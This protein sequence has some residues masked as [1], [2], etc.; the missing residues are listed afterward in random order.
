METKNR[1]K[2]L[3][4]GA[5]A[6]IVLWL[7]DLLVVS[8]LI[9]SWHSRSEEIARLNKQIA[10]G[11]RMIRR[12]SSIRDRWNTMQAN[13][14]VCD[15]TAAQREMF[16]AFDHW[17]RA[18]GVTEGSFRPDWKEADTNY[19]TVDCRSDVSGNLESV[20]SF[21]KAMTKD[22]L[23]DKVDSFELTSKDDNGRQLALVLNLSGLALSNSDPAQVT[24]PTNT[25]AA[26]SD[27]GPPTNSDSD[28]FQIISH[29][30]IFD[31]SRYPRSSYVI[32]GPV[33]TVETLSCHG[34]AI[35]DGVASAWFAGAAARDSRDYT[36][37]YKVGDSI[38]DLKIARITLKTVT[39]T[40]DGSN[41]FV[42]PADSSAS[43]RR[44]DNGPWRVSGYVADA[45]PDTNSTAAASSAAPAGAGG[46]ENAILERLR[47]KRE[48]ESQ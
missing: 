3:M 45:A 24:A 23:A 4:I 14:L 26:T 25:I 46:G 41:T 48:Q 36:R 38:G 15:Q 28:P 7:L 5:A 27:T 35:D 19:S 16:T 8:P 20:T 39:L 31:Q 30:N 32:R 1:E 21:L 29:N 42:L 13:A 2:L 33:H 22:P 34:S 10:E 11:A 9:D 37:D 17:V 12:E 6:V 47:K 43:L 40:N 18:G 44:E